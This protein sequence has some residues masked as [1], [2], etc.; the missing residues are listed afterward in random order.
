[1][2]FPKTP[3]QYLV[4]NGTESLGYFARVND[5]RKCLKAAKR[6]GKPTGFREPGRFY[7][8]QTYGAQ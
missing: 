4:T 2:S 8:L 7:I 6:D 1:M 5:A 3:L